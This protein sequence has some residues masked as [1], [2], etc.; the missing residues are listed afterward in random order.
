MKPKN[1]TKKKISS[2]CEAL[3][4]KS[5]QLLDYFGVNWVEFPNRLA[6]ACPIHGGDNPEGCCIFT[7]GESN[8]GN[9]SCWTNHCEEEHIGNLFG[10]VRGCLKRHRN[11][12]ISMLETA[13]FICWFLDTDIEEIESSFVDRS[14]R[15]VDV[16]NRK[17]A[18]KESQFTR[19][20][21]R[22]KLN[23]PSQY[24]VGRGHSVDILEKF[25]IGECTVE[26]QPM[27]GRVVVP[28]YDEDNNYVGCVGR[29]IKE[30]LQPKWLHSKGFTKNILYGLN[31][32]KSNILETKTVIL[33]EGQGD[34]W[35]AFESGLDMTVGIF[36]TSLSE[37]Q[38][39]LLESSGALNVV[40]LTDYDEA[41]KKSADSIIKKCGRRFNYFRP[42]LDSWFDS[43]DI[44]IKQRDLGQMTSEDIKKEIIPYLPFTRKSNE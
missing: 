4:P 30:H 37:D 16:F 13:S 24:F 2:L 25:D 32:A 39:I 15:T 5:K 19:S 36:G 18:R 20:S 9:W 17:I 8:T 38:L 35:R 44:P 10:F 6:F 22:N 29:A 3:L 12:D 34:V 11:K 14:S 1:L 21:I 40:I 41:G 43:K 33:V 7:D 42:E 26:N 27:S 28:L 31:Y 23:I